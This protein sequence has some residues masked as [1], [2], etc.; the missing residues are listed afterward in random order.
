MHLQPYYYIIWLELLFERFCT[1]GNVFQF[2]VQKS[3]SMSTHEPWNTR[4]PST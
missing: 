1:L 2:L 3:L 4:L